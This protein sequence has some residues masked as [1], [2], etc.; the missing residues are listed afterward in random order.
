[1]G[2]EQLAVIPPGTT[3]TYFSEVFAG[4]RHW[5]TNS[6]W[7]NAGD[8]LF[9]HP[10]WLGTPRAW[11]D[12]TGTRQETCTNLPFGDAW[13]CTNTIS[14][15]VGFTG[16]KYDPESNLNHFQFR[17][18]SPTQ[19]RWLTPDPAG[20][21][22]VDSS[23]PQ[24]WN[25][26]AYVTNNPLSFTD[27][28]GLDLDACDPDYGGDCGGGGGG[29]GCFADDPSCSQPCNPISDWFCNPVGVNPPGF[30]PGGPGGGP[31]PSRGGPPPSGGGPSSGSS[32]AP[33]Q[34]G[35]PQLP[36]QPLS[37]GD[38]LGLNP[39]CDFG[40]CNSIGFGFQG[41]LTPVEV[42]VVGALL[43]GLAGLG[44]LYEVL[45]PPKVDPNKAPPPPTPDAHCWPLLQ[46]DLEWCKLYSKDETS[47]WACTQKAHLNY[48]RCRQGLD[49][50]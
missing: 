35:L 8:T 29:G 19:G 25:R 47:Y 15:N 49:P 10:D 34:E 45:H 27:P 21:A 22:A 33:W 32:R 28:Q 5:A 20:L 17:Q 9:I 37:L 13:S 23:S 3:N 1:V 30:P 46:A 39:G 4:G 38:L 40:V 16:Q 2:G 14:S 7:G 26:Y 18:Q 6:W 48:R 12:M 36:T 31:P 50:I 11:T 24:S 44:L 43:R 42:G 41:P